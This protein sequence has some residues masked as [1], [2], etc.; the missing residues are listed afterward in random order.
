MSD[1]FLKGKKI[2]SCDFRF[3]KLNQEAKNQLFA[4]FL[5]PFPVDVFLFF[6]LT[7]SSSDLI[8]NS[9][10]KRK[11]V[12]RGSPGLV[13]M[14]GDCQSRGHGFESQHCILNG[15]YW[16]VVQFDCCFKR[17]K[18][19]EKHREAQNQCSINEFQC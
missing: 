16:R 13:V 9:F 5:A 17:P 11:Q 18:I 19:N 12:L 14:W 10:Y 4:P 7:I 8:Q 1:N 3:R 15:S 6:A 2:S